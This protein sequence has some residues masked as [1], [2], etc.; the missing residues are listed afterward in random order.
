MTATG[1]M[2]R[3]TALQQATK[4]ICNESRKAKAELSNMEP[5]PP[6]HIFQA[7]HRTLFH[8]ETFADNLHQDIEDLFR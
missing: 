3:L 8:L 2:E 4:M 7:M 1:L 5:R 6:E